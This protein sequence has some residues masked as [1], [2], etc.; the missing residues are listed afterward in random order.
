MAPVQAAAPVA[1]ARWSECSTLLQSPQLRRSWHLLRSRLQAQGMQ[2]VLQGCPVVQLQPRGAQ[3][4]L[5]VRVQITQAEVAAEWVRG[6]LAD[7]ELVDMGQT[8][9]PGQRSE[10]AAP[11][12]SDSD[13]EA[14]GEDV[15]P[16]V[17]F[18]RQWLV[19]LMQ[20]HGWQALDGYWWVFVPAGLGR[21]P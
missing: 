18:N 4:A 16:D 12:P 14:Q 21:L 20:Q 6:P 2:L 5:Q 8:D 3:Q 10:G 1:K 9:E 17:L 7:G 11:R 15:S 13:S 19:E